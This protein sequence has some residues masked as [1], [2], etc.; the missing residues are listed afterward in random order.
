MLQV[1]TNL[2]L[3]FTNLQ[4][5]ALLT[6]ASVTVQYY[7]IGLDR[8]SETGVATEH[9]FSVMCDVNNSEPHIGET[10]PLVFNLKSSVSLFGFGR[11]FH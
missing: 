11:D 5:S 2:H 3:Q 10:I 9:R 6:V 1:L 7:W 8:T 4:N